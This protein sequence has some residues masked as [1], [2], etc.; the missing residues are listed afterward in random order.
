[1]KHIKR[2]YGCGRFIMPWS[3]TADTEKVGVI[4][5]RCM[6]KAVQRCES[7]LY[8]KKWLAIQHNIDMAV[9]KDLLGLKE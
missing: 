3:E 6:K 7:Y 8:L 2:C 5:K 9:A 4:H 1:M